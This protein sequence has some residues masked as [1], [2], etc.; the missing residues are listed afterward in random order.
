MSAPRR[1][2]GD[3][4][5]PGDGG[6]VLRAGAGRHGR[7]RDQGRAARD[8]RPDAPLD[9]R[10]RRS[11]PST[12]TSAAITLN[13]KDD[14][15]RAI[16]HRLVETADV[17]TENYRPGVAARLG[18][19]YETL[20]AIN[21]R[22]IYASISG[23]GQTGPYAQRPGLRPDRPGRVRRDERHR[24]ARRQP[25]QVRRAR[26]PTSRPGCSAPSASCRALAARE[27]TGEGQQIDT[28]L[29]EGALALSIWE[30][31]E[32]WSTG[33]TPQPMGSAHR[34]TAP[35]Q[36]LRT[37]DGHITVGGNNQKLWA[38]LCEVIGRAGAARTTR[39]S[40][41]TPTGWRTGPRWS[42]SWSRRS[43]RATPS[44]WVERAARRRRPRRPDPR[45]RAGRRRPAHPRA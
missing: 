36:A 28:S 39:A 26:S 22:L 13:L 38:R 17:L 9:G 3:R 16:L 30:T 40:R 42:P 11:A 12:A 6:A 32:L 18:A 31:A 14:G 19:D 45:L 8:R 7:R 27:R 4:A 2:A 34:L 33:N 43:P 10:A 29:W 44:D 1:P 25:G 41:P 15:D 37:R 5:L 21:P 20:R 35:Y 23:F 24:R